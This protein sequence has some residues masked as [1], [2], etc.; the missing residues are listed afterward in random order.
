M[1]ILGY[2]VGLFFCRIN[3]LIIHA[4]V[5]DVIPFVAERELSRPFFIRCCF[6][7][8]VSAP[9]AEVSAASAVEVIDKDCFDM[10]AKNYGLRL[11]FLV[12][13]SYPAGLLT[14]S[15]RFKNRVKNI[16]MVNISRGE[17]SDDECF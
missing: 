15:E 8:H 13:N 17:Y 11:F 1:E 10:S 4:M 9:L 7:P 12:Y 6:C 5:N 2:V 14:F 16:L 3:H